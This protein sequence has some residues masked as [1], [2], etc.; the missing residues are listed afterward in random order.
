MT[1]RIRILLAAL[2]CGLAAGA[3]TAKLISER[4]AARPL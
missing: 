4:P 2:C 3:Q 1:L